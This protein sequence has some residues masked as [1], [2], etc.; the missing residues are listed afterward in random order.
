M[1]K[2]TVGQANHVYDDGDIS[3]IS[4]NI[5]SGAPCGSF[6]S[7]NNAYGGSIIISSREQWKQVNAFMLKAFDEIEE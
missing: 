1:P 7:L 6:I 3:T 4:I 5:I 2:R